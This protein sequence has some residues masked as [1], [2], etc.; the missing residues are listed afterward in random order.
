MKLLLI[1]SPLVLAVA[2]QNNE[3]EQP[4]KPKVTATSG[5]IV[6]EG[7]NVTLTYNVS[8]YLYHFCLKLQHYPNLKVG[9]PWDRC[10]WFWYVT[11]D[12]YNYCNF[13]AKE[14]GT[15]E[16]HKCEPESMADMVEYTG[17]DANLCAITVFSVR[18]LI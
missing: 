18:V 6:K 15:A 17:T 8:I 14:D 7:D 13:D 12:E 5:G 2:A 4:K 10:Y 11:E 3:V 9:E 16:L 1:L